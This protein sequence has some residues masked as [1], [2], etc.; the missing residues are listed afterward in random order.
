MYTKYSIADIKMNLYSQCLLVI[1]KNEGID[2]EC[3]PHTIKE[4]IKHLKV[5]HQKLKD[6][7]TAIDTYHHMISS[8]AEIVWTSLSC[9]DCRHDITW[10]NPIQRCDF[11]HTLIN[12]LS[13]DQENQKDIIHE[14]TV[15]YCASRERFP[16]LLCILEKLEE[17][18]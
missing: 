7:R 12:W 3:L 9:D 4:D 1:L 5:T 10:P 18:N 14:M 8:R 13:E 11:H 2:C 16:H 6:L 15:Q 17:N